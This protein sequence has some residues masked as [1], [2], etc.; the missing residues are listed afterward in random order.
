[1][2]SKKRSTP[3]R[4]AKP[5]RPR[6]RSLEQLA[7]KRR[8]PAPPDD[9]DDDVPALELPGRSDEAPWR[10][11]PV[12]AEASEDLR[13]VMVAIEWAAARGVTLSMVTHGPV[14]VGIASMATPRGIAATDE[15]RAASQLYAEYGGKALERALQR[16]AG[17]MD[18]ED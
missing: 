10:P 5:T 8:G 4:P 13:Q 3:D 1:M 7:P 18:E 16:D 12:P 2:S 15:G 6:A 9:D 11:V 17:P 14:T